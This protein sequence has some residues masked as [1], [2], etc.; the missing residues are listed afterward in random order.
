MR[1]SS[2]PDPV[3]MEGDAFIGVRV[4]VTRTI[5]SR[6][7]DLSLGECGVLLSSPVHEDRLAGLLVLVDQFLRAAKRPA[8]DPRCAELHLFY[9]DALRAGQVDNWDLVD[10]SAEYLVGQQLIRTDASLELL[11]RLALSDS[12]WE[13]RVAIVATFAFIKSGLAEPTFEV[14]DLLLQDGEDLIHKAV[15][16]MLREVGKRVS[17]EALLAFLEEN[18]GRMPRTALSYATEHLSADERARF[19]AAPR[20]G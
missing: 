2:T 10:S 18:A 16:W 8:D 13:R 15:G 9:L 14:S 20:I 6:H 5:V 11:T 7:R 19:R 4:P 1:D 3:N 17:R 12:L